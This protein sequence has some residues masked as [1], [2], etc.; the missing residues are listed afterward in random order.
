MSSSTRPPNRSAWA[1][2]LLQPSSAHWP[3]ATSKSLW[4]LGHH[5]AQKRIRRS[6]RHLSRSVAWTCQW[7]PSRANTWTEWNASPASWSSNMV[8][9]STLWS[10]LERQG[11][12]LA[13]VMTCLVQLLP[14]IARAFTFRTPQGRRARAQKLTAM[15]SC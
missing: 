12:L 15:W 1:G 8:R 7:S 10:Q 11:T 13:M 4:R 5:S 2:C 9:T 3:L 6:S 14:M